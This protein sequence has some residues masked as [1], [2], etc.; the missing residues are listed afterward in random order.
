MTLTWNDF[1][2]GSYEGYFF[3]LHLL[4]SSSSC[5]G[6]GCCTSQSIIITTNGLCFYFKHGASVW[7]FIFID[8]N[9]TW[10][11]NTSNCDNNPKKYDSCHFREVNLVLDCLKASF[12]RKIYVGWSGLEM[13][14]GFLCKDDSIVRQVAAKPSAARHPNGKRSSW[15][16]TLRVGKRG[17]QGANKE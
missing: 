3:L 15:A 7:I 9:I 5:N 8:V 4:L 13:V 12:C 1:S 16:A 14:A 2:L 6:H 17:M 11:K 10:W